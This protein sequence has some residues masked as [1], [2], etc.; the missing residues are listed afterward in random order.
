MG[1][2]WLDMAYIPHVQQ[3]S[4]IVFDP[5]GMIGPKPSGE[6]NSV[7]TMGVSG[8]VFVGVRR[9]NS[10]AGF[11]STLKLHVLEGDV[12]HGRPVV[13]LLPVFHET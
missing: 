8:P 5:T 9:E 10:N 1:A 7:I 13:Q 3:C 6:T 11:P 12:S 4:T 2:V